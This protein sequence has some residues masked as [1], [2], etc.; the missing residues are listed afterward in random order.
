MKIK[1]LSV[2]VLLGMLSGC[3]AVVGGAVG[4][5]LVADDAAQKQKAVQIAEEKKKPVSVEPGNTVIS[6]WLDESGNYLY[7]NE[8]GDCLPAPRNKKYGEC[9]YRIADGWAGSKPDPSYVPILNLSSR[10]TIQGAIAARHFGCFI[11]KIDRISERR[12]TWTH[13]GDVAHFFVE[14]NC[15][16]Q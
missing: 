1:M 15:R 3:A 14:I 4:G 5:A 13:M 7:D 6:L 10:G 8:D 16:Q 2:L 9:H 12:E 11:V